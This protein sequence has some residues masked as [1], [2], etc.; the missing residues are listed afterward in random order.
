M[1]YFGVYL[2]FGCLPYIQLIETL[3]KNCGTPVHDA[4]GTSDFME[5][6]KALTEVR[7]FVKPLKDNI[8]DIC[9][10]VYQLK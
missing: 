4:I 1:H 2:C 5:T 3:T 9:F 8:I 7:N 6:M 10:E